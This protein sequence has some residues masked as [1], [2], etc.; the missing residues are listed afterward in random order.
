M[1]TSNEY[2]AATKLVDEIT[3]ITKRLETSGNYSEVE[4]DLSIFNKNL[5]IFTKEYG[6]TSRLF[7][8]IDILKDKVCVKIE[9]NRRFAD[10]A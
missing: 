2:Q 10:Y 9:E 5:D 7:K 4:R 8:K 1:S 3:A 6:N